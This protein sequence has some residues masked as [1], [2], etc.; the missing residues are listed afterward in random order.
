[1]CSVFSEK[2]NRT[3]DGKDRSGWQNYAEWFFVFLLALCPLLQNYKGLVVDAR[4]TAF[5]LCIPFFLYRFWKKNTVCWLLVSPVIL[6][7]LYKIVHGG[8]AFFDI[9]REGLFC[10]FLLVAASGLMD[11][12]K[13]ITCIGAIATAASVLII[14]QYIFYYLF[15]F[16]LQLVPTSLLLDNAEQ[17]IGMAQTGRI[18]IKGN[19]MKL[20]RPSAF[21][22]EPAHMALY[23][24][25]TVLLLLLSPKA[26]KKRLAL[27]ALITIGVFASTSGIG[28]ALCLGFWFLYFA[29]YCGEQDPRAE[30][31]LWKLKIKEIRIKDFHFKGISKGVLKI[32]PFTIKGWTIRPINLLLMIAL[33]VGVVLLYC[34]V[35]VFR[36]SINRILF[37]G[38]GYNAIAGRVEAGATAVSRL[39]FIELLFGARGAH[40]EADWY[41]SA[42]FSTIF[43]YGMLGFIFSYLFYLFSLLKLK[44]QHFW[45]ALMIL[46]LSYFSVHTHGSAYM[47]FYCFLLIGGFHSP[48]A[49]SY[50]RW[51]LQI[52][53]LG[54]SS[55]KEISK[56]E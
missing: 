25:P 46:G 51:A 31:K 3:S 35:G 40:P 12:K 24:T 44:R 2:L 10:F 49:E 16:H 18:S 11:H 56:S 13:F 43:D 36:S 52:H 5:I 17:W 34:F 53:P 14:F 39:N 45:M 32:K 38:N 19:W 55:K 6:F 15:D 20:Y 42:F 37:S 54:L 8:F 41:M 50:R 29:L 26:N 7:S 4:A 23:C 28:I 47:L 21:F 22:L 48:G 27:A 30:L 33:V 1:M 9:A